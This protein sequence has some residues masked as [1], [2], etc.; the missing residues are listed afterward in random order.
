MAAN[1][2]FIIRNSPFTI[3]KDSILAEH[4]ADRDTLGQFLA[5]QGS[6]MDAQHAYLT[7]LHDSTV[8]VGSSLISTDI[9]LATFIPVFLLTLPAGLRLP[10]ADSESAELSLSRGRTMMMMMVVARIET[11]RNSVTD[12]TCF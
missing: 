5:D 2:E 9:G 8:A 11:T 7:A 1:G 4:F 10:A 12:L 6:F 3:S